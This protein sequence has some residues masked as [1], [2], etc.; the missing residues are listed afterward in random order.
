[1]PVL[2]L[3]AAAREAAG[4]ARI[5]LDGRTVAEVLDQARARYGEGFASVL[6]R[7][8]VW[9]NG[10]P[11]DPTTTLAT[12]DVVAVLPPVSGGA[13]GV[14]SPAT[15]PVEASPPPSAA[16]AP[17]ASPTSAPA[18]AP[19][20]TPG[21]TP[22]A[23]PVPP[24]AA[25]AG[26]PAAPADTPPPPPGL[27]ERAAPLVADPLS[28]TA[29]A[30]SPELAAEQRLTDPWGPRPEGGAPGRYPTPDLGPGSPVARRPPAVPEPTSRIDSSPDDLLDR[31]AGLPPFS[32]DPLFG[33]PDEPETEDRAEPAL[34]EPDLDPDLAGW[35][36]AS[37]PVW[38][39][40]SNQPPPPPA[41]GPAGEGER[42]LWK[43]PEAPAAPAAPDVGSPFAPGG[44]GSDWDRRWD[45]PLLD[46]DPEEK[47]SDDAPPPGETFDLA[48]PGVRILRPVDDEA[49]PPTAPVQMFDQPAVRIL[50]A[51]QPGAVSGA[52][53]TTLVVDAPEGDAT[54]SNGSPASVVAPAPPAA[55]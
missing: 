10:Q 6:E 3:F 13:A 25:S 20:P 23:P 12:H 47:K 50:G 14:A 21:R 55:G 29:P 44:S 5:E 42:D 1:M 7:S 22:A 16:S 17:G 11:A 48:E 41:P 2:R 53:P 4:E 26:S 30:P 27:D 49:G 54:S 33:E 35:G 28:P 32:G 8:R 39:L 40:G 37:G 9:L 24:L 36:P 45:A 43:W 19:G 38:S 34:P 31:L 52:K 51:G 15:Q 46:P 18:P